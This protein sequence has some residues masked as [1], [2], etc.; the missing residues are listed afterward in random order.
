MGLVV[1][2]CGGQESALPV[3]ASS[4]TPDAGVLLPDAAPPDVP[5]DAAAPDAAPFCGDGVRQDAEECDHQDFGGRSCVDEGY[6][7]GQLACRPEC[8][9]DAT[10]CAGRCG[11]GVINGPEGC[12]DALPLTGTCRS[13]GF[14][15]GTPRCAAGCAFGGCR[16]F[17]LG[18]DEIILWGRDD[19]SQLG[20]SLAFAGDVDG[21]GRDDLLAA[22]PGEVRVLGKQGAV[23]LVPG[24][25][26][27]R[28]TID[29]AARFVD[30]SWEDP[31]SLVLQVA[32]ARDLDGDG[33]ADFVIAAWTDA[34]LDVYL[35]Y[36]R[37]E[38]FTGTLKLA[39]LVESGAAAR[40]SI[41]L[42]SP[43]GR[44]AALGV[45]DLTGDGRDDLLLAIPGY[46]GGLGATYVIPGDPV[47]YS[48]TVVLPPPV[49]PLPR[50]VH[51]AIVGA[52]IDDFLG[53]DL[54][55]GD[56]D[57]DGVADLFV[58]S[59]DDVQVFY[60]PIAGVLSPADAAAHTD[61]GS[62]TSLAVADLD[63]DHDAE[64]VV[65]TS[66]GGYLF[67]GGPSRREGALVAGGA[68]LQLGTTSSSRVRVGGDIDGDGHP[69]LVFTDVSIRD[70][71]ILPGPITQTG[72]LQLDLN[73]L[74][75]QLS[76][77][78]S[79]LDDPFDVCLGDFNGDGFDDVAVATV[80]DDFGIDHG[81]VQIVQGAT[82]PAP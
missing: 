49:A 27:G 31:G 60:G 14:L 39:D 50:P 47:R 10:G 46:G 78:R 55:A 69:D 44:R 61:L 79:S 59:G 51:A 75:W 17:S 40:F 25:P 33:R 67:R 42:A 11:D 1:S 21:D 45:P 16:N 64:L 15:T 38:S 73:S 20:A 48:G 77:S 63:G 82:P 12:D 23:Y 70:V 5:P 3:D 24:S 30:D 35:V 41:P 54:A 32:P 53:S 9:V 76:V 6:Y 28:A 65:T 58:T 72:F 52:A 8:K 19:T 68:D 36:G 29:D 37:P 2:A 7:A 26:D 13:R 4:P 71:G 81:V 18:N 56:L 43:T 80:G 66:A 74:R 62:V 22:A 57:G 34:G